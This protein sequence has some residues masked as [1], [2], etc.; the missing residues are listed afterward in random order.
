[1]ANVFSNIASLGTKPLYEKQMRFHNIITEF[2]NK[3]SRLEE[4]SLTVDDIETFYNKLNNFDFGCVLFAEYYQKYI[5]NLNRF[6]PPAEDKNPD[7]TFLLIAL[8]EDKWKPTK[9]LDIFNYYIRYK[10]KLTSKLFTSRQKKQNLKK[11]NPPEVVAGQ[12]SKFDSSK[13]WIKIPIRQD[14]CKPDCGCSK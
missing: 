6:K 13:K 14:P 3:L 7:L 4:V 9:P 12:I 11:L 10:Y 2:R 5:D 8:A 1:M